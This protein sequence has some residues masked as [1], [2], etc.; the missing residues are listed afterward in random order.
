MRKLLCEACLASLLHAGIPAL[1][2]PAAPPATATPATATPATAT[3]A[4]AT[5][6]TATPVTA[7]PVTATPVTAT[8]VTAT[9]AP[10]MAG[11]GTP[12]PA[13]PAPAAHTALV[14]EAGTGKVLNLAAPAENIFVADPKIAEVRPGQRHQ[15]VRVR[16]R[17]RAHH[18]GR[19]GRH[20]RVLAQYDLTVE[21]AAFGATAA[22]AMIARLMPG[23]HVQVEAQAKG[24]LL[25]G[26]V[27]NPA[28]A[29]QA[30]AIAKG[31]GGDAPT[32]D[33]QMTIAAPTQVT[34]NVRIARNV[35][36][37][38]PQPRHQ[39]GRLWR[40]SAAR[41]AVG[42]GARCR[43]TSDRRPAAGSVRTRP[44]LSCAS[45]STA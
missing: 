3:P 36:Q 39:L 29:A 23:S 42:A 2:A 7:I 41:P 8:P 4:T 5:P 21:P 13:T 28:E 37:G 35:A 18:G 40:S 22:Q 12:A 27:A 20:G 10:T 26:A 24:L 16:R 15:P 9:L 34:L 30:V 45:A 32:V 14:L 11:P 17:G 38:D 44:G 31:Y 25:T 19:D 33:N 1:A 6:V 43:S